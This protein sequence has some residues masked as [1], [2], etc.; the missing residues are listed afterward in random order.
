M[1]ISARAL[2][3]TLAFILAATPGLA[4]TL[5]PIKTES[6]FRQLV[7]DRKIV[8]EN[9]T[10]FLISGDG[11]IKGKVGKDK[12]NGVWQWSGKYFC[13]NAVLGKKELGSDCQVLK[14]DG[15]RLQFNRKKGKEQGETYTI[16]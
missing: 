13:R 8:H 6:Q 1:H 16:Q 3:L 9:G 14:T 5:K 4:G 2:P 7:V 11:K 15:S 12:L 10:W